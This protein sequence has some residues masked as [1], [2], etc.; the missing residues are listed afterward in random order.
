MLIGEGTRLSKSSI[1]VSDRHS[2]RVILSIAAL[3]AAVATAL[4]LSPAAGPS[5]VQADTGCGWVCTQIQHVVI[6]EK[7][8]HTFDNMFARFPGADGTTTVQRGTKTYPIGTT[9]DKF[10]GDIA[11]TTSAALEAING[12]KMNLF[13]KL[14]GA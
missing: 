3:I 7:E 6:I 4:L 2:S 11:H 13:Y 9:P 1:F 10:T 8:N 5:A 12:G 14:K